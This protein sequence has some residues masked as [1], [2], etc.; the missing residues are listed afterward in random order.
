MFQMAAK[1]CHEA[2]HTTPQHLALFVSSTD[3]CILLTS[4]K[5]D[6]IPL[7]NILWAFLTYLLHNRCEQGFIDLFNKWSLIFLREAKPSKYPE[8]CG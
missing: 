2:G 5:T 7:Q 6:Q 4:Y 3:A 8:G 1:I